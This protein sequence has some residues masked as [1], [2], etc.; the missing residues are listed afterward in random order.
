MWILF[1]QKRYEEARAY[2]EKLMSTDSEKSAVEYSHCGDIYAMC[3]DIEQ[4]MEYWLEAQK[5]GDNSKMLKRKIKKKK[6]I[7]DEKRNKK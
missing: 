1:V 7:A 5:L 6:Y 3:G 2:A 4:A